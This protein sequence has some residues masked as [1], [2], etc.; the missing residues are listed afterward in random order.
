MHYGIELDNVHWFWTPNGCVLNS[1]LHKGIGGDFN[2][3]FDHNQS[4]C[5]PFSPPETDV[6][7]N[8]STYLYILYVPIGD[9]NIINLFYVAF[10]SLYAGP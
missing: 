8:T 1:A 6:L 7:T 2:Q 10:T 3:V 9:H 4:R 5:E